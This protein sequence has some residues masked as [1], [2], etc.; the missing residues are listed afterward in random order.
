V[1]VV[2]CPEDRDQNFLFKKWVTGNVIQSITWGKKVS[3]LMTARDCYDKFDAAQSAV[4][5]PVILTEQEWVPLQKWTENPTGEKD[6]GG[7][8]GGDM[9]VLDYI[10]ALAY[11]KLME[12]DEAEA[13]LDAFDAS[14]ETVG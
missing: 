6:W 10:R 9:V 1:R 2:I 8:R 11:A 12:E 3:D 7:W 5:Y 13:L 14:E 4:G